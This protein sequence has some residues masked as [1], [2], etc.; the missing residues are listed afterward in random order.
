MHL[1]NSPH[2]I[3][4]KI[5]QPA[6][7][8]LSVHF[9]L[10]ILWYSKAVLNLHLPASNNRCPFCCAQMTAAYLH[11]TAA[12]QNLIKLS[13]ATW[14]ISNWIGILKCKL[15]QIFK[16]HLQNQTHL[17][18]KDA[19]SARKIKARMYKQTSSNYLSK[20]VW[21]YWEEHALHS[22]CMQTKTSKKLGDNLNESRN[23][24]KANIWGLG[25]DWGGL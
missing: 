7:V 19:V 11:H 4:H 20:G 24:I 2:D 15:L 14:E 18:C 17:Q 5:A 22:I 12:I 10:Y 9:N 3:K 21:W 6:H 25:I 8:F 13:T 1:E 16:A 23:R